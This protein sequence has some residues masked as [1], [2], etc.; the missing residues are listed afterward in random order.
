ME[1]PMR[2]RELDKMECGHPECTAT[3]H[4]EIFLHPNCHANASVD[5]LYRKADG[6]LFIRCAVCG[7]LVERFQIAM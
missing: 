3:E 5:A 4:P 6:V 7:N 2:R 1:R